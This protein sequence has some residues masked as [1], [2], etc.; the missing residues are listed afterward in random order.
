MSMRVR[1]LVGNNAYVILFGDSI[2]DIDGKRFFQ[3][4]RE[5]KDWL[6]PKGLTVKNK[7][8]I[9]IEGG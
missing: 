4:V 6:K 1:W 5:L 7:T 2:V 3:S 8:V 9:N